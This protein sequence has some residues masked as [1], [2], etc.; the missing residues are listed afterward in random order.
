[1]NSFS[2]RIPRD[3]IGFGAYRLTAF[4]AASALLISCKQQSAKPKSFVALNARVA[5][6]NA[7]S[8]DA[9]AKWFQAAVDAGGDP[10]DAALKAA[11]PALRDG[12]VAYV[13]Q[14]VARTG[15]FQ[16]SLGNQAALEQ[17]LD[18]ETHEMMDIVLGLVKPQYQPVTEDLFAKLIVQ[19]GIRDYV[20]AASVPVLQQIFQRPLN[21]IYHDIGLERENY[22]KALKDQYVG[23]AGGTDALRMDL[24]R[25]CAS[26]LAFL[27]AASASP[28]GGSCSSEGALGTDGASGGAPRF[29]LL[30]AGLMKAQDLSGG[31][32]SPGNS[33]V[34]EQVS[35]HA[36]KLSVLNGVVPQSQLGR[37]GDYV[38]NQGSQNGG[39]QF[40][41]NIC[42]P[43]FVL[44]SG[45]CFPSA[46]S[47]EYSLDTDW[48]TQ[49]LDFGIFN[50]FGTTKQT[51][52]PILGKPRIDCVEKGY[53]GMTLVNCQRY[54]AWLP[55]YQNMRS[56][57]SSS[58]IRLEL[59]S[60]PP[61]SGSVAQNN[62]ALVLYDAAPVQ[63]QGSEGACTAFGMTHTIIANMQKIKKG[64]SFD[65]WNLWNRY[66]QPY[67]PAAA[68]ATRRAPLGEARVKSI[69][70]LRNLQ[71][72]IA[73]IDQRRAIWAASTVDGSWNGARK[74][75][76]AILTCN[77]SG[78]G[79]AY[80]LHGYVRDNRAPGGGY[81][82]VKNS[83]GRWW[84]EDGYA[85]QPFACAAGYDPEA[86]DVEVSL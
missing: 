20:D 80:S 75:S 26:L 68:S 53:T 54:S 48:A 71:D 50:L 44:Q 30:F 34:T 43:G 1:M 79:H 27:K 41:L 35:P 19:P 51:N 49:L 69:R 78:G 29:F 2:V 40:D 8:F 52:L 37:G 13:Q 7:P 81:F 65:A 18:T 56:G 28:G 84:G 58:G 47:G 39:G 85:Y 60:N 64:Y 14:Q 61:A 10:A 31:G 38:N 9:V 12:L 83:W 62:F 67:M 57:R 72:M 63:N 11:P 46:D 4:A 82:I 77:G 42:P 23:N 33:Q 73:V 24:A 70:E 6:G 22:L 36:P 74:G 45:Q 17:L 55:D 21:E 25:N 3:L 86:Y 16:Q 15:E 32:G 59:N 66:A 5:A 76:G